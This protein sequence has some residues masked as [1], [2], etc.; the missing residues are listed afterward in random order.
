MFRC[1]AFA[2]G[3]LTP[4]ICESEAHAQVLTR[5]TMTAL[6]TAPVNEEQYRRTLEIGPDTKL[7][8]VIDITSKGNGVLRIANLNLKVVDGH[9]D[10]AVYDRGWAHI[11][12]ADIDD[13]GWKDLVVTGIVNYTDD[14]TEEIYKREPFTFIYRYDPA[15]A[16]FRRSYRRASFGLEDGP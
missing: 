8:A 10:G 4:F 6:K 12:F 1:L 11:E 3:V 13:D 15:R 9:D 2:L 7:T 5:R 16:E 14:K